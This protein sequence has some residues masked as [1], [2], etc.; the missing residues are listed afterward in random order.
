MFVA[1]HQPVKYYHIGLVN[2]SDRTRS[3]TIT[4]YVEW[5]CG[6]NPIPNTNSL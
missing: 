5:V 1:P 4:F 2:D 3:L 6:V